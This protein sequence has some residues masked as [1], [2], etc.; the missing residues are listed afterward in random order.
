MCV[1]TRVPGYYLCNFDQSKTIR[2]IDLA[3]LNCESQA[4]LIQSIYMYMSN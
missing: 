3:D 4:S 1:E 2:K